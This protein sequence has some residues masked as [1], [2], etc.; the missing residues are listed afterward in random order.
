MRSMRTVELF[1]G[2]GGFRLAAESLGVQTVWANDIDPKACT[3]YRDRFGVE[4]I[5]EGDVLERLDEI[6]PHDI[7][8]AGFPCQP[9]SSAGKKQ[10]IED[11][12]GT[13]FQ[14]I[15]D[16][17]RERQPRYFVLENV[18]RL[19]EMEKGWHFATILHSL[20]QSDYRIEWRL[21]NATHF[22]LA[23]NRQRVIIVGVRADSNED[24]PIKLTSETELSALHPK[25]LSD[26]ISAGSWLALGKHGSSFPTWGLCHDG[27]FFA[28]DL[29]DFSDRCPP[30]LLADVLEKHVDSRFDFTEITLG[31]LHRNTPVERFVD[32]VQILSN[33]SGG[34]RMGYTIFGIKGVAPTLTASTSRHYERYKIGNRYRRLTNVE[35]A[36]LQGFPDDYCRTA[37]IYDQY[38]LFGN[39]VPPPLARWALARL[40]GNG[41]R[42][43]LEGTQIKMALYA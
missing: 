14:V 25:D 35:Y 7:L 43:P 30:V 3:V 13:L 20:S 10:G 6:P 16:V 39:A 36:R 38:I 41:A 31:W 18:K 26:L 15:V 19:L 8:S 11:P 32:G 1:A 42:I 9:F 37:S 21:L 27:R 17:L 4:S 22:G 29:P 40:L 12:R 2:I 34:A 24:A 5:T 23:Q 33:Q 28:T